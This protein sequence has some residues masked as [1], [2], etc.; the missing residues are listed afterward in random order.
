MANKLLQ[1]VVTAYGGLRESK[2]GRLGVSRCS[3]RDGLRLLPFLLFSACGPGDP[4]PLGDSGG[5]TGP[6]APGTPT[7]GADP[8]EPTIVSSTPCDACGGDCIIEELAYGAAFHDPLP[9]DYADVPPAGGPHNPCWA[10]F[11]V[12][13]APVEDDRWVHNLEHGAIVFLHDCA[14]A[15][16][17]PDEQAALSALAEERPFVLVTPY[18]G[19]GRSFAAI[20]WEVRMLTACVDAEAYA[21]FHDEH[22]D[23][24]PESVASGPPTDCM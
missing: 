24:G 15:G 23:R 8:T 10:P 5:A 14:A 13:E 2:L 3:V 7:G 17:C 12:H 6:T 11:G 22:V 1:R 9:I 18:S 19:L 4:V 20:G 16:G 21:T